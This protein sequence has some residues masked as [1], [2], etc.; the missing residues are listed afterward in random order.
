MIFRTETNSHNGFA[1]QPT[2]RERHI[3]TANTTEH[4]GA[5]DLKF[6]GLQVWVHGYQFPDAE[7]AWDGN[8]LRVTAH[9]GASG[10]S[11]WVSGTFLDT[12]AIRRFL[13][14]LVAMHA[15]LT[16]T[17][18]LGT[19]EPE[20]AAWA[21]VDEHTG[22]VDFRVEITSDPLAQQHV[23]RFE[24]DQSYLPSAIAECRKLLDQY[25]VR[26]AARRPG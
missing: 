11:V 19:D 12:V 14:G 2:L 5:P 16:G 1:P 10:A 8:W 25:P 13:D 17:A 24:A 6:A 9:C 22:H 21:S 26:D 15:S 23:F 20:L 4:L 3:V 18:Q 7:D